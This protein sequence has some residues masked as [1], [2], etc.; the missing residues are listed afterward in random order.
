MAKVQNCHLN[1][2]KSR[3]YFMA[4]RAGRLRLR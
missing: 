2:P 1:L 4:V 3:E